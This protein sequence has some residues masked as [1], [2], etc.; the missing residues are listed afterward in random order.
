MRSSALMQ[1]NNQHPRKG[2]EVDYTDI[3]IE[4]LQFSNESQ[5]SEENYR[6]LFQIWYFTTNQKPLQSKHR[7]N[8]NLTIWKY[9]IYQFCAL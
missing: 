9:K 7:H 8:L 3:N 1:L 6:V 5:I 4:V 2:K